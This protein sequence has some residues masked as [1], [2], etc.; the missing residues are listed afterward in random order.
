MR[1]CA[2][3]ILSQ[4]CVSNHVAR[5]GDQV[6]CDLWIAFF[7]P[8]QSEHAKRR[9][10]RGI[11]RSRAAPRASQLQIR[12]A[13][14][15]IA[16]PIARSTQPHPRQRVPGRWSFAGS[17]RREGGVTATAE[18]AEKPS[19]RGLED[20]YRL[21][22]RGE[23]VEVPAGGRR[24]LRD[25]IQRGLDLIE[26]AETDCDERP[27]DA[28]ASVSRADVS[29]KRVEPVANRGLPAGCGHR[30]PRLG[31]QLDR[32]R[33]VLRSKQVRDRFRSEPLLQHPGSCPAMH[34]GLQVRLVDS[35][36]V[37]E[38]LGEEMVVAVPL[39]PVVKG[40]Q[41]E[42]RRLDLAQ[43]LS[44]AARSGSRHRKAKR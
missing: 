6:R 12:D 32:G 44:R 41:E 2:D 25:R 37:P 13:L 4:S 20:S 35:Q 15:D 31:D 5:F 11:Q 9:N 29:R 24:G 8:G 33:I 34:I 1:R 14:C 30:V 21:S 28:E 43:D 19:V 26:L 3:P 38:K 23:A 36:L 40:H 42:V 7:E 39:A 16:Q 18:V 17:E 27:R 22:P 10:P